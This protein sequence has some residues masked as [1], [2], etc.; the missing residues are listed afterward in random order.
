MR[1]TL[2]EKQEI[3]NMAVR[4]EIGIN[5]TLQEIGSNKSI[6]YNWYHVYSKHCVEGPMPNK[7]VSNR[8]LN[9]P[10]EQKNLVT[11]V[12]LDNPEL[13]SRELA[14]KIT[15]EHQVFISESSICRILKARGLITAPAHIFLRFRERFMM[16]I[17]LELNTR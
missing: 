14:Y 2:S 16:I 5:R 9:S 12:E 11:D 15:D 1:L 6:F 13:S 10:E 4:S 8:Q 7:R 3:I 17:Q